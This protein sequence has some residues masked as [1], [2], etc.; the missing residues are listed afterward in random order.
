MTL[1][2]QSTIIIKSPIK[3]KK[4]RVIY[5]GKIIDFGDTRYQQYKDN[6]P[7]KL[8]KNLD[9]GDKERRKRYKERHKIDK[10][11][12]GKISAGWLSSSLLW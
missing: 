12:K 6:T 9:H 5:N 1:L 2:N 3:N 8:Y 10:D 11:F 7:L 4:Y